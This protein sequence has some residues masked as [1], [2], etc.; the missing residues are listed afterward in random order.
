MKKLLFLCLTFLLPAL[1]VSAQET[2]SIT[3]VAGNVTYLDLGR[4]QTNAD[5][6]TAKGLAVGCTQAQACV[7][8]NVAGGASCT[9]A[10]ALAAG[11]RIWPD[12]QAGREGFIKE[13]L[14][15][16]KLDD[17]IAEQRRRDRKAFYNWCQSASQASKDAACVAVGQ[18][19]GCYICNGY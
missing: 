18:S 12:S 7:A 10:D 15:K 5:V 16:A 2:Y 17:F 14:I 8:Y 13:L 3:L 1:A 19:A 6:C 9:A 4:T 11:C